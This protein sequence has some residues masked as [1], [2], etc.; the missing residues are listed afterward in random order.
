M[1]T[2]R[3]SLPQKNERRASTLLTP[4]GILVVI[5]GLYFGRQMWIPLALGVVFAFLLTPVVS[6]LERCR[7]G[8]VPSV[9]V[10]MVLAFAFFGFV[11]WGVTDQLLE[12]ASHLSEYKENIQ[13]KMQ[14]IRSPTS[15]SLGKATATM[16]DLSKDLTTASETAGQKKLA[17]TQ[18]REPIPVQV[19]APP[20]TATEFL[21][22]VAG[23]LGGVLETTGIVVIF[24]L[25]ILVKR[26]DL[27]NR[28]LRLAGN[29]QFNIATRGLDDASQRLGRYLFLQFAVNAGFGLLF[30]L[31]V[32]ALGIPHPLLWGALA[33]LLR[34][35]PYIGSPIAAAF[36]TALALAV[37]PGW[38]QALLTVG[39]FLVMEITIANVLEPWL[40]GT[41]TGV[42]SLAILVAAIFWSMLWGPVGLILSTPLTVCLIIMGSY[43]SELQ[44]LTILLGDEPVLSPAEHFYQRL[45]ALDEDEAHQIADNYL[46][47]HPLGGL[48]DSMLVPAL[49]LAERDRHMSTLDEE[50]TTFINQSTRDLIEELAEA[51]APEIEMNNANN[52]EVA[53]LMVTAGS[54]LRTVCIPARDE[55]DELVGLMVSKLLQRAGQKAWAVPIG[56]VSTM[57]D[58]VE[59][60]KANIV[61]VSA[62]PPFAAGQARSLCRQLRQRLPNVHIILGL[63]DFPGGVAKAQERV[64]V[65]C[66]DM[67]GTSLRQI[68]SLVAD[69]Q[70]R[71]GA[72]AATGGRS[73]ELKT[74]H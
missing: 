35:V 25:F 23:P 26:E 57:L 34:F 45:L 29:S 24:T 27:R 1:G 22:D 5:A 6:L 59:Q 63:W 62:L 71:V 44:F 39:L 67:V 40:Y 47:E 30:G 18:G 28:F 70:V 3:A 7:L 41:H 15:G 56:S 53:Q 48:F 4:V 11:G 64:G 43:I 36:P 31:G 61:C 13:D 17:R 54:G 8:R 72:A 37:F 21:R 9:L 20:H 16:N 2:H 49:R 68:V 50:R 10:V 42:S 52:A 51:T 74:A 38:G 55:A 65:G 12:I 46:K 66:T 19:A 33:C 58:R 32:F 60:L 14:A 69:G 73:E